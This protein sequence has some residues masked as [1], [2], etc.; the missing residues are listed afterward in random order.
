MAPFKNLKCMKCRE[1][2]KGAAS[3]LDDLPE[4]GVIQDGV[5]DMTGGDGSAIGEGVGRGLILPAVEGEV[6][7]A[8]SI[9]RTEQ[10]CHLD[11]GRNGATEL[12]M[13]GAGKREIDVVHDPSGGGLG[14]EAEGE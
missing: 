8:V 5:A 14:A 12:A 9:G 13:E 3:L 1:A 2:R 11:A 10:A 4:G 7:M 6:M